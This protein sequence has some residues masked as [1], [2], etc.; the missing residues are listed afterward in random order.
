M[1]LI[2]RGPEISTTRYSPFI[3]KNKHKNK[4]NNKSKNNS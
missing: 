4:S 2:M 1:N 3:Y